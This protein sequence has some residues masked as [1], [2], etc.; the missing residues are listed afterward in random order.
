MLNML[1]W[2]CSFILL[3]Y[4]KK[5]KKKKKKKI[6]IILVHKFKVCTSWWNYIYIPYFCNFSV[7]VVVIFHISCLISAQVCENLGFLF[8][9][10]TIICVCVVKFEKIQCNGSYCY[11][12]WVYRHLYPLWVWCGLN[13]TVATSGAGTSN[14]S[15]A[16]EFT[17]DFVV[18]FVLLYLLLSV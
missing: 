15:G 7:F 12:W 10:Y 1:I 16:P 13:T 4:S 11:C 14:S 8:A 3:S 6:F 5:K 17:P 2:A 18:G 9:D